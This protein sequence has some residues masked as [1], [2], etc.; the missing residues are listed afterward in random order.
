MTAA[1]LEAD[2]LVVGGG[3]AGALAA[4]AA[5]ALRARVVLVRRAPAATALSSGAV[6]VAPDVWA[7][8][9]DPL[10]SRMGPVDAARKLAASRPDHPYALVGPAAGALEEALAFAAGELAEVLCAPGPRPLHLATPYG[11]FVTCALAQ[12]SMTA[13]DLTTLEGG[14][15][16][17]GFRG[18]L[19]FDARL[20]AGGLAA[21][22]ALRAVT[23]LPLELDLF[24]RED[25]ALAR[26]HELA[27]M[28][29]ADGEAE[30]AGAML[31]RVLPA[32][33]RVAIFPPV[34][35][36]SPEARVPERI[37]AAA[38]LPVAETVADVPSVPGLRLQRALDA[39]LASAGVEIVAGELSG[40]R[41]PGLP[42]LVAGREVTAASWVL[43][44]GRFV[45][46][47]IVR[48][49]ALREALLGIPV[50]ASEDGAA[51]VHLAARPAAAL[52]FRER[53]AR[54]P[55]LAAGIRVD[56]D[57]R[58]LGATGR[59]VHPRLFAAGAVIGGHEVAADGTGLGV[60]V[61]TGY[62]AGR[63]AASAR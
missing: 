21:H 62:L 20:V 45:G 49:G 26:P 15:A 60:A 11:S 4:L 23:P 19:A 25:A 40:A 2:V 22:P 10:A 51:G 48:R 39:R 13:G 34:L 56:R 35:G 55:L 24:M 44:T 61:L 33:A 43:A 18:H 36:L 46:G 41:E 5:R 32:A 47:G 14:L 7:A 27:R 1:A 28:L 54:Q 52:T 42:A 17:V 12:R 16:V 3:M 30:R 50:Q 57:L 9:A 8:P 63:M 38:G 29:E 59:P 53:R 6:G 58:P 37:A 31:R